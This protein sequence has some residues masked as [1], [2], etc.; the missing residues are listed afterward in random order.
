[1]TPVSSSGADRVVGRGNEL[2]QLDAFMDDVTDGPAALLLEGES[3]IGKTTLWRRGVTTAAERG[4]RVLSTRPA[5][6]EAKLSYAGLADL[7]QASD[8]VLVALPDPQR[9]ALEVALLKA[10]PEE[11]A[12]DARA[13]SAAVL[14]V[15]REEADVGP[16]LIALDDVQWLDPSTASA[17]GF[18][19]RRLESEQIGLLLARRE[20]GAAPPF[21]LSRAYPE[22]RLT[23]IHLEPLS[24]DDLGAVLHVRLGATLP[25]P[26][27]KRLHEMSGGNPFFAMEIARAELRGERRP[28]GAALP[29]PRTLRDDLLRDRLRGLPSGAR[30][31]LLYASASSRPTVELVGKA[32]GSPNPMKD[33][34]PAI[35]TGIVETDISEIRFMH[36]LYGSAIYAEASRDHRHRVH[37]RL[38]EVVED[39]EERARHLA[40]AADG[41]ETEAASAL[42]AAAQAALARGSPISAAELCEL[43]ERLTPPEKVSDARRLRMATA[44]YVLLAGDPQRAF[45]LLQPVVVDTPPG[46]ERAEAL[47]HLGRL[48]LMDDNRGASE[49]LA[50]ALLETGTPTHLLSTIHAYR[51]WAKWWLGDLRE[52]ER[53]A[54]EAVRLAELDDDPTTLAD[55]LSTLIGMRGGLGK[56]IPRSLMERALKFEG[57]IQPLF[58]GDRPSAVHAGQLVW[59]GDLDEARTIL[60]QLLDEA[61]TKGDEDSIGRLHRGLG[62][63]ELLAGNWSASQEHHAE[64]MLRTSHPNEDLASM[65]LVEA[66]VGDARAATA[67]AQEVLNR[68]SD[69]PLHEILARS[70][71]G[72]AEL[73]LGNAASANEHLERA[74]QIHQSWGIGEPAMFLFVA[75]YVEALI[76]TGEFQAASEILDWL[77]ERGQAL[78]RPWALAVSARYRGLMAAADGDFQAAF[79][80]LNQ[81]LKEHERLPMPFELGRTMLALGT[82]RRRAKQKRPARVVLEEALAIFERLGAPLWV[83]KARAELARIGGRRSAAGQL[84]EAETRVAKLAAAGRTNREIA[85]ALFMSVRTVEGHLSHAY[86]KL[87]VRSRTELALFFDETEQSPHS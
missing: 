73:S 4:W 82:V 39:P 35:D 46:P 84:T 15:L 80:S 1:M 34:S 69:E 3:G 57:I 44:D 8:E 41:P 33:L 52:A 79:A 27:L 47:F 62:R 68:R 25:R 48:L 86:A 24:I 60:V 37:R 5:E 77:E 83:D 21:G 50:D 71:L 30:E 29:V 55:A 6:S 56:R 51:A 2:S 32:V 64:S 40:L 78:D 23:R 61:V 66:F 20:A 13:V 43:A 28:T 63:V 16:V 42:E 75:D 59:A 49:A 45:Q 81:A 12:S 14:T 54:E 9:N 70:A 18:A 11:G 19:V 38:A 67:D 53:H 58:V 22:D 17:L 65:A 87:G 26:T 31:A 7:L 10:E 85:D 74:W 72:L 76:E 36:P